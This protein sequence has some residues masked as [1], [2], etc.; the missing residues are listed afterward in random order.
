VS[1]PL[2]MPEPLDEA[3]RARIAPYVSHL[4][5]GVFALSG[6]PEEVIAVLFAYY[7]RS[8]DDLRT[9]LARLLAD[10]EVGVGDSLAHDGARLAL[11][12][13]KARAFHERWVVGYGH[14]SVAEHAVVH[15]GVEGVSIVASKIIEDARLASFTEKSTR[16]VVFDQSSAVVPENLPKAAATRLA[17]AQRRLLERYVELIPKALIAI[18][19][20][21][22]ATEGQGP[23][24]R[25]A[26]VRAHAC[27]LLRGLL[28]AGTRTNLGLTA[29]A[30]TIERL[31]TKLYS[32]PLAECRVL[33]R[34]LHDA[35]LTVTPT[36]VK[37]A[38]PSDFVAGLAPHAAREIAGIWAPPPESLRT[39]SVVPRPVRLVRHDKD[40]LD[41]IVLALA[42]EGSAPPLHA[43]SVLDS[44]RH[45]SSAELAR[46]VQSCLASRGPHDT[47]PRALEATT[48]TFELLL[49]YGAYRD[50]QRHRMLTP[51]TQVLGCSVGYDAPPELGELGLHE[52]FT[53][54][55][56]RTVEEWTALRDDHP[57]EAQ[58]LVPLG[59]RV[60]TLWTLNLR[61][62]FHVI[63]LRTA[64]QGHTSYR[65]IARGLYRAA[66]AVHP[67]LASLIRVDLEDYPLARA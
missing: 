8:R 7:S 44:L 50:L 12:E 16:Y 37:Y 62:L 45:A 56:L 25:E 22:P 58:Y 57:L 4:D 38:A 15:L 13:E 26:A 23:K 36:L 1:G 53:D 49:D 66:V 2:H 32:H 14:A 30:R 41:R 42:Y 67:W 19:R 63:E 43:S 46:V 34:Q 3:E 10:R 28:P 31:L 33:A 29:N 18:D 39:T 27:D 5:G 6:L 61:Q 47:P 51:A 35:A 59:Y 24:A 21:L 60:R 52:P 40:A 65:R 11:A 48:L 64:K 54:A 9:N 20:R 55:M 17:S